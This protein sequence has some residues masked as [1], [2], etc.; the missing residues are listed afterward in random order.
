MLGGSCRSLARFGIRSAVSAASDAIHTMAST[1]SM[2]AQQAATQDE[3][4]SFESLPLA[5]QEDA[6]LGSLQF[7]GRKTITTPNFLAISSRGTVPHI[8][9]DLMRSQTSINGIYAAFEDCRI[10]VTLRRDREFL[11]NLARRC[12]EAP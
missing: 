10:A 7:Q 5:D 9:Q 8:T 3:V 2:S 6:R 12:R 11:A 4:C 1:P